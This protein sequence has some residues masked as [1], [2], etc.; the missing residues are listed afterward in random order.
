MIPQFSNFIEQFN[1]VV[2]EFNVNVITDSFGNMSVDVPSD[3]TDAQASYV[4]KKLGV[5]DK[6]ITSHSCSIDDLFHKGLEI[7][8]KIKVNKPEYSSVLTNKIVEFKLLNQ[9]Y[10]H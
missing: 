6:L 3:M 10:K 9:S 2:I 5:I 7:E 1:K 8:N 4:S